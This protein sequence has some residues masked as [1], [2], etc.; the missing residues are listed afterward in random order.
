MPYFPGRRLAALRSEVKV[1]CAFL[2][3]SSLELDDLLRKCVDW[4]EESYSPMTY[5]NED[6]VSRAAHNVE[7][8]L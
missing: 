7:H 8:P 2:F 3:I 6:S 4:L 1:D 5:L